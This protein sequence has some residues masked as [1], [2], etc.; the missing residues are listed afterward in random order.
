MLESFPFYWPLCAQ[1]P[2]FTTRNFERE[3][4]F[5]YCILLRAEEHPG[6]SKMLPRLQANPGIKTP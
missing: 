1:P 3:S 4:Q 5:R 2:H 6:T